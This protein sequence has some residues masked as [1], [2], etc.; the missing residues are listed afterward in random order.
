MIPILTDDVEHDDDWTP[1][2]SRSLAKSQSGI[3]DLDADP[4]TL[5]SGKLLESQGDEEE[6]ELARQEEEAI[7]AWFGQLEEKRSAKHVRPVLGQSVTLSMPTGSRL[8]QRR[9]AAVA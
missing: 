7:I 5:K 8:L 3:E 1:H 9:R 6:E 2:A 4:T